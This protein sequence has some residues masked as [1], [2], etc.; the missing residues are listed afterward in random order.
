MLRI[1]HVLFNEAS[2][3]EQVWQK[4]KPIQTQTTDGN[5]IEWF[6]IRRLHDM[7]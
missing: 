4:D 3:Q 6:D 1:H 2:I 7:A 5:R